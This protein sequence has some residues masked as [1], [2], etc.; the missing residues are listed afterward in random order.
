MERRDETKLLS[1]NDCVSE[2]VA[3]NIRDGKLFSEIVCIRETGT[4]LKLDMKF[5]IVND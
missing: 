5:V 1:L 2:R 3:N 4:F